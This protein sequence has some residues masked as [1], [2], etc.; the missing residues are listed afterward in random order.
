VAK[1]FY[2]AK[3]NF[4]LHFENFVFVLTGNILLSS[5][6]VWVRQI[7]NLNLKQFHFKARLLLMPPKVRLGPGA[8][9]YL[10]CMLAHHENV[11]L[12]LKNQILFVIDGQ[13]KQYKTE[14]EILAAKA[15]DSQSPIIC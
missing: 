12:F 3:P 2:F 8:I 5:V 7:K 4:F 13:R 14:G 1:S 9:V 11:D 10:Q 15:L 6:Y